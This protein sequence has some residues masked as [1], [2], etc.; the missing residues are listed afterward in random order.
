MENLYFQLTV[1]FTITSHT[2]LLARQPIIPIK[3]GSMKFD[4]KQLS[5]NKLT[6]QEDCYSLHL[7]LNFFDQRN[8]QCHMSKSLD[9]WAEQMWAWIYPPGLAPRPVMGVRLTRVCVR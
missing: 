5:A 9:K 4:Q 3:N 2:L 7:F 6:D 8:F 1:G